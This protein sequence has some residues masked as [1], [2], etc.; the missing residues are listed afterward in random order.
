MRVDP[1]FDS[2]EAIRVVYHERNGN[3]TMS[4]WAMG[5]MAALIAAGVVGLITVEY[6]VVQRLA[7]LETK[8]DLLLIRK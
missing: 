3:G 7:I 4:R 8:V 6:S 5:I 2:R 1:D